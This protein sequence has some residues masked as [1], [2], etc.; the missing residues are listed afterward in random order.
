[1]VS[2]NGVKRTRVE[3]MA[4]YEEYIFKKG[5]FIMKHNLLKVIDVLLE[6]ILRIS[7][8]YFLVIFIALAKIFGIPNAKIWD[9]LM[10][11][12]V[13][14]VPDNDLWFKFRSWL[15]K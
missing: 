9:V 5:R 8:I 11:K 14:I 3:N 7:A 2:L 10:M 4:V 1:M 13:P 15:E 12:I 6:I